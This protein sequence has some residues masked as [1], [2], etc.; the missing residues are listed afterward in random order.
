MSNPATGSVEMFGPWPKTGAVDGAAWAGRRVEQFTAECDGG[1]ALRTVVFPLFGRDGGVRSMTNETGKTVLLRDVTA[2]D[3]AMDS[4]IPGE[5]YP[6]DYVI[7]E[8]GS[9]V[10]VVSDD[11]D[12]PFIE[13]TDFSRDCFVVGFVRRSDIGH[14]ST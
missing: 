14:L 8:A 9:T 2:A 10:T 6:G 5:G 4:P 7:G 1:V 12:D 11:Q 13:V 3:L